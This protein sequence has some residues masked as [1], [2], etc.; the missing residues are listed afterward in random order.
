MERG[1]SMKALHR[2][3]VTSRAY[4]MQSS[5]EGPDDPN[6]GI[7]PENRTSGG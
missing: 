5:G 2:L 7:D 1:W 4:R 3:I 6:Y